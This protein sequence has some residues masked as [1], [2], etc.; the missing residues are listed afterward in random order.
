MAKAYSDDLRRKVLEAHERG[1][2]TLEELAERFSVSLGWV[3][4]ISA[5]YT[6]TGGMERPPGRKRGRTSKIT[7]EIEQ[8]L[9]TLVAAQPD[10][11]LGELRSRLLQDKQL[12]TSIGLLWGVLKKLGLRLKKNSARRRAGQRASTA[13]T[14]GVPRDHRPERGGGSDLSR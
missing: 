14:A 3:G 1:E 9:R 8:F 2:G 6:R 12:G 13:A 4:K 7:P 5:A 11:T 10:A